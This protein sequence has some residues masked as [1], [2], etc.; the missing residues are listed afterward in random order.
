[1]GIEDGIKE[2]SETGSELTKAMIEF[3]DALKLEYNVG[4]I[5]VDKIIPDLVQLGDYG[6]N[7]L[8]KIK[9]DLGNFVRTHGDEGQEILKFY[10]TLDT[11]DVTDFLD[12]VEK[13]GER[14]YP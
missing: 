6:K 4:D 9:V 5:L 10:P 11:S 3:T 13:L 7:Q 2:E 1:M 14:F 12:A 8:E